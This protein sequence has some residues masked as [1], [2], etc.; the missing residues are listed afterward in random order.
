MSITGKII[1]INGASSS[2]K[3]TIIKELQGITPEPFLHYSIDHFRDS[4]ILP[5]DRFKQKDFV[6]KEYREQFFSGY[7]HS[8]A[9]FANAGNNLIVEHII[10][11]KEWKLLFEQ[12]FKAVDLYFVGV[13]CDL[14]TL[15]AREKNRGDRPIGDAEKDFYSIHEG[16]I[17]DLELD[18]TNDAVKNSRLLLEMWNERNERSS[19]FSTI[20]NGR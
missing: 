4:G 7:H 18:G 12:L 10:E 3:T 11:T 5:I 9:S 6:W 14:D 19:F 15:K 13:H 2:G 1:F 8:I 20:Y 17:Y 16:L